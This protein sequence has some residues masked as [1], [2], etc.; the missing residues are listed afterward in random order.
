[1]D[2]TDDYLSREGSLSPSD[3]A[4]AI[5]ILEDGRYLMQLRDQKPGIFFPGHWGMFGGACDEGETPEACVRRELFE[6]LGI[7]VANITYFTKFTFDFAPH[8]SGTVARYYYEVR[9]SDLQRQSIRLGEGA[10]LDAFAGEDLL[11]RQRV[12]PYDAFAIW[13]HLSRKSV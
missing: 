7:P 13:M 8:Q 9:L 6:E 5:L 11:T 4:V 1:M 12:T 2:E 3:A 10:G